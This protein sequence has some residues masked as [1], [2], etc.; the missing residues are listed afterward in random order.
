[1]AALNVSGSTTNDGSI[2]ITSG[3]AELAGA[4]GGGGSFGLG[5]ARLRFDSSVS[6]GQAISLFGVRDVL[7]L[8][9]AQ[10]F[11]ATIRRF[12]T[13]DTIDAANFLLSGTTFNFAEN[14]AN[15]G[16]TLT[17][18]DSS[19]SLTGNILMTGVYSNSNFKLVAD[20]GTGTLVKFV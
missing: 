6:A 4:V 5:A 17:L 11:A 7:V 12:G 10:S 8:E 13:G 15:T 2:S 16:G 20:G 14:S 1:L 19:Q 18:T 9:Q 3:T